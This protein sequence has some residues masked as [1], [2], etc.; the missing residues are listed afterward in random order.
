MGR[1]NEIKSFTLHNSGAFVARMQINI[2]S[3]SQMHLLLQNT[4]YLE[5]L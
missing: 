5:P 2:L 4:L 3:T 1:S